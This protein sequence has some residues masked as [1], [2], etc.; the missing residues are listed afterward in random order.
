MSDE[1]YATRNNL[2][3]PQEG[4]NYDRPRVRGEGV[5]WD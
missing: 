3:S 5:D 2:Y 4:Y 1:A